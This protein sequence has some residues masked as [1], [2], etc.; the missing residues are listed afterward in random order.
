MSKVQKITSKLPNVQNDQKQRRFMKQQCKSFIKEFTALCLPDYL[1]ELHKIR[2]PQDMDDSEDSEPEFSQNCPEP[3][4]V[5][6][7]NAFI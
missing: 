7:T 6:Q 4:K 5:E 3:N 2:F 1:F